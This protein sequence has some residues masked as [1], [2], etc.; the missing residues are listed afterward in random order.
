MVAAAASRRC[1]CRAGRTQHPRPQ[2]HSWGGGATAST[3]RDALDDASLQKD[4]SKCGISH[5][6]LICPG[7]DQ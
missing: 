5:G 7:K 3:M 2:S 6:E 1:G 4:S